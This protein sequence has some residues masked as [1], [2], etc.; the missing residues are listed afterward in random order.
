MARPQTERWYAVTLVGKV[1]KFVYETI[2]S[3]FSSNEGRHSKKVH[4]KRKDEFR[5]G[6]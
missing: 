2:Q 1:L 6:T 3:G 4:P 5:T